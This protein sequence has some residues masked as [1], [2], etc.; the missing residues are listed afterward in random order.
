[1]KVLIIQHGI[2]PGSVAPVAKEYAKHLYGLGVDVS[3]AVIGHYLPQ[4]GA[5][6]LGF[7]VYSIEASNIIQV[8]IELR[9]MLKPFNIVHYFPSKGME[10]MPLLSS[11]TKFIFN[12][13]SVSVTGKSIRDKAINLLKRFQPIFA[14]CSV[15]TDDSL[16][17][18]LRPIGGKKVHLLPVGFPADLFYPCAPYQ[19]RKERML[20]YHGAVRPQ[21]DLEKLIEVLKRLPIEYTLMIIGGGTPAD[22]EY[23]EYL[24]RKAKLIGCAE[25]LILTNM[26]QA[27]IRAEIEKAYLCLSY[28]PMWDCYQDQFVLKTLEYLACHRPVMTTATRHSK[29]FTQKIGEG[30]ILLTNGTIDDM[31]RKIVSADK[32]IE[33]FYIPQNLCSLTAQLSAYSTENIVKTRLLPLYRSILD[34]NCSPI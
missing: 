30:H 3:V 22:D 6:P 26:P 23:R 8:Y 14:D 31:V 12:R 7:P 19:E 28:V 21:R 2:F 1:M 11:N 24:G 34:G 27:K 10:L 9:K 29:R 17:A 5:E 20:I 4:P 32:Y 33:T 16:A 15:F 18:A 13:L 25:R